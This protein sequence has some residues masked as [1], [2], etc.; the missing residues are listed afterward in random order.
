MDLSTLLPHGVACD[1]AGSPK[2]L[3]QSKSDKPDNSC[4]GASDAS[5]DAA[6]DSHMLRQLSDRW[7][8][9][10]LGGSWELA[11]GDYNDPGHIYWIDDQPV[12]VRHGIEVAYGPEAEEMAAS[13]LQTIGRPGLTIARAKDLQ[14]ELLEGFN[15]TDFQEELL[16]L[17]RDHGSADTPYHLDGR[18][19]LC[20]RVQARVLPKYGYPGTAEGVGA[21]MEMLN[22]LLPHSEELREGAVR[23]HSS[24][25]LAEPDVYGKKAAALQGPGH[26]IPWSLP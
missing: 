3:L 18:R 4:D 22:G 1:G 5:T 21:M 9:E 14:R 17:M 24:L 2:A 8:D 19:Q 15:S 23:I 6:C 20:L 13:P 12:L 7:M 10:W 16:R 25:G 26:C 11:Q